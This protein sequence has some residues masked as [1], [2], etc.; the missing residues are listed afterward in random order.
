MPGLA[1]QQ[2]FV[3]GA[4][5]SPQG[6]GGARKVMIIRAVLAV[7]GLLVAVL[8]VIFAKNYFSANRQESK[9]V[10]VQD[11]V[12]QALLACEGEDDVVA[13][14]AKVRSDV[15]RDA[16]EPEACKGLSD[17]AYVNCITLIAQD[18]KDS[19]GCAL[20]EDEARISCEDDV[21]FA[22]AL[23]AQDYS[24]C[25]N[26]QEEKLRD[27]CQS[28]LLSIVVGLDA[29][30]EFGIDQAVCDAEEE[31][32][33]IIRLGDPSGCES[34]SGDLLADCRDAFASLDADADGLSLADEF[35]H[36]TDPDDADTDADGYN[37]GV[38]V[39]GGYNPLQ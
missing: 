17:I 15:A 2:Y 18:E 37:D 38:E 16:A 7:V 3:P 34:L 11:R 21:T 26:L 19:D 6:D 1:D 31:L 32:D 14:E 12:T 22:L 28:Q 4:P 24:A 13:C 9:T 29:C 5:P 36:G 23:V 10:S 30:A 25:A 35:K 8:I 20:L 33:R 39:A 27:S